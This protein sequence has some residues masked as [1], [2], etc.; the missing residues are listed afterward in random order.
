MF[1]DPESFARTVRWER[2]TQP[3][4]PADHLP[5]QTT[6][7]ETAAGRVLYADLSESTPGAL[8]IASHG[9]RGQS[10]EAWLLGTQGRG[11]PRALLLTLG[12]SPDGRIRHSCSVASNA[13]RR[14]PRRSGRRVPPCWNRGVMQPFPTATT[15]QRRMCPR[16][17]RFARPAKDKQLFGAVGT[18]VDRGDLHPQRS[19]C[20]QSDMPMMRL[21]PPHDLTPR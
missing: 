2:R 10:A 16:R 12:R 11:H 1:G 3:S 18:L 20:A 5:S 19:G 9:G 17:V 6:S 7:W 14:W 15:R 13:R 21:R 8:F 4:S